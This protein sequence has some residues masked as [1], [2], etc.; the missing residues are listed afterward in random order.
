V[1]DSESLNAHGIA[2][3]SQ[4]MVVVLKAENLIRTIPGGCDDDDHVAQVLVKFNHHVKGTIDDME[5]KNPVVNNPAEN[6][7]VRDWN[8]IF[9][10]S[11]FDK[12]EA[13]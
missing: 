12:P 3:D 1:I 5:G 11:S 7:V 10:G 9:S 6:E 8:P 4:L 2:T 13:P